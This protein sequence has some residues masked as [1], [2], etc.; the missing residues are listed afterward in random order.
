MG[1]CSSVITDRKSAS[2]RKDPN[3]GASPLPVVERF[4]QS[5]DS[6][7]TKVGDNRS[8][9]CTCS[10]ITSRKIDISTEYLR[11]A[12]KAWQNAMGNSRS[13]LVQDRNDPP[14]CLTL[15]SF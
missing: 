6:S 10:D 14:Y 15:R 2:V 4:S 5:C 3:Y 11:K 8:L 12:H 1:L 7:P 13:D 9:L